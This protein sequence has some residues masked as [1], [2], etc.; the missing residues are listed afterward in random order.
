MRCRGASDALSILFVLVLANL[1]FDSNIAAQNKPEIPE[2]S[3]KE[4]Y[5]KYEYRIP[6]RDGVHCVHVGLRPQRHRAGVSV[7]D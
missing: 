2:F 6:M 7:P 1:S 5:T 3:V 4:H